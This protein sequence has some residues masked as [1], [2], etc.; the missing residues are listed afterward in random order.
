LKR[1][2]KTDHRPEQMI[3]VVVLIKLRDQLPPNG[4]GLP[5]GV[6]GF[7]RPARFS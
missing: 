6:K 4:Q 2:G 3:A 7:C 5:I 1:R